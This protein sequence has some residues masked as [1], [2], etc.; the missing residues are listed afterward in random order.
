MRFRRRLVVAELW[1]GRPIARAHERAA[2][3]GHKLTRTVAIDLEKKL[4]Q[5]T[6]DL[7][8]LHRTFDVDPA[9]YGL[10]R[11]LFQVAGDGRRDPALVAALSALEHVCT[12]VV[13]ERDH[14]MLVFALVED[15]A[16]GEEVREQIRALVPSTRGVTREAVHAVDHSGAA[17]TWSALAE[18]QAR[19]ALQDEGAPHS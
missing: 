10:R 9:A 17:A 4:R 16:S 19:R 18:K 15:A 8:A 7:P 1:A 14:T 2:E 12:V 6:A 11:E 5:A 3:L 13:L